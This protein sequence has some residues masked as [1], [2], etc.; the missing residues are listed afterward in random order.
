[1]LWKETL[2][3]EKRTIKFL[4]EASSGW[5]RTGESQS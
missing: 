3:L 5:Y 2:I 4:L 1:M